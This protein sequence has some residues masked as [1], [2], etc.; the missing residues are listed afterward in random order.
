MNDICLPDFTDGNSLSSLDSQCG[1]EIERVEDVEGDVAL[2]QYKHHG[3]NGFEFVDQLDTDAT[4]EDAHM[5]EFDE[6][7]PADPFCSPDHEDGLETFKRVRLLT[8][9][10]YRAESRGRRVFRTNQWHWWVGD[11][12]EVRAIVAALATAI[13]YRTSPELLEY[14]N[15]RQ[16]LTWKDQFYVTVYFVG[17]TLKQSRPVIWIFAMNKAERIR[18]RRICEEIHWVRNH[19]LLLLATTRHEMFYDT[20]RYIHD[21]DKRNRQNALEVLGADSLDAELRPRVYHLPHS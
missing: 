5:V 21:W 13:A 6:S 8:R 17:P 3:L 12:P 19:T 4:E 10:E 16:S 15:H 14:T 18:L 20:V 2:I 7:L 11:C 1:I 9:W